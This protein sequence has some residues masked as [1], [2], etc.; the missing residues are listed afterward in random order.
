[1]SEKTKPRWYHLTPDKL[2]FALLPIVGLLLLSEQFRWFAFNEHKNWTVLIA[3]AVVGVVVVL[4]LLWLAVSLVS[5]LRFQFSIRSLLVLI[6]VVAIVCSWLSVRM[7]QARRQREV[8]EGAESAHYDYQFDPDVNW[9]ANPLFQAKPPEPP[10]PPWLRNLLGVDFLSDVTYVDYKQATD[11]GLE[12][13]KGL[14]NLRSLWLDNTQVTDAGLEHLKGL[15]SLQ[16]LGL[17]RTKVTDAGLMHL[18][19]LTSLQI[20]GLDR[21]QVTDAGLVHLKGLTNLV[22]LDLENTEVADVGLE[23]LKGLDNLR[24][25]QEAVAH[26]PDVRPHRTRK[27]IRMRDTT[28]GLRLDGGSS[29]G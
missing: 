9:Q 16:L 24:I 5:R 3:V 1:M 28:D 10:G 23:H 13:L 15:T 19:G 11:A 17:N 4:L 27:G 26:G 29:R 2:L 20:L 8:V 12:H 22:S 25:L 21:T 18:K 6:V 7:Q 14:T